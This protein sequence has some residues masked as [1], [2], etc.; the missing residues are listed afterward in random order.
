MQPTNL[1]VDLGA[2]DKMGQLGYQ[3]KFR[4]GHD[5]V[6]GWVYRTDLLGDVPIAPRHRL[7]DG[8]CV[9]WE[10]YADVIGLLC[11]ANVEWIF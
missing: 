5:V 1:W 8:Y 2:R 4:A 6:P 7:M 3:P 9:P 11:E 10:D